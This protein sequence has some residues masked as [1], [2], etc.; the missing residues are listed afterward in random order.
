M[1]SK[2]ESISEQTTQPQFEHAFTFKTIHSEEIKHNEN[3]ISPGSILNTD[4]LVRTCSNTIS[5][6]LGK[7]NIH[8]CSDLFSF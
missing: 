5:V 4:D 6:S 7:H 1:R 2:D 3:L 8:S